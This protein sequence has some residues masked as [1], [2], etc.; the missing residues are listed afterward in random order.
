[1]FGLVL[2]HG[3]LYQILETRN[4]GWIT[5]FA[6]LGVLVIVLQVTGFRRRR[7]QKQACGAQ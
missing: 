4:A 1:V 2:A 6:V 5:A 3:V 7:K